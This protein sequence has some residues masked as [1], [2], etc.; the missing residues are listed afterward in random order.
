[1][2]TIKACLNQWPKLQ[3]NSESARLDCECLL[4]FV[5]QKDR[6]FLYTWPERRLSQD[7]Q[8]SFDQLMQRRE[9]GEPI[10]HILG[11]KEFWSLPLL[12]DN[13]TLIPRPETE[14]LVELTL[15]LIPNDGECK[16]IL[17]LGT[18]TGAIALAIAKERPHWQV[19]AVDKYPQA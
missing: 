17:D 4:S 16:S 14:R 13:S 10:A 19:L 5:L 18:G 9:Q 12:V 15:E 3:V 8:Q 1:M 6:T 7:Q 2:H 11:E